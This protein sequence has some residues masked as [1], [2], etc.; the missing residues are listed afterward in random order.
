MATCHLR[1]FP[2][3]EQ[4]QDS[5]DHDG[6][7][8]TVTVR[9]GDL[10]QVLAHAVRVNYAWIRDFEDDEVRVTPDFYDVVRAFSGVRPSA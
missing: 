5:V 7:E 6:Q 9:L 2:Y 3:T 10:Y 1:V 4:E 8:A